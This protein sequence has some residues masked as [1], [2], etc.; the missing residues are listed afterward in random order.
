MAQ[1]DAFLF[2]QPTA[3]GLLDAVRRFE[4]MRWDSRAI[5]EHAQQFSRACF[6]ERFT[7]FV[8]EPAHGT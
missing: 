6:R 7:S 4:T 3:K 1:R 2:A 8:K 5:Q